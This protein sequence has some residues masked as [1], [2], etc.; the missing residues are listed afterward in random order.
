MESQ[1]QE[2]NL[3]ALLVVDIKVNQMI[4]S[5]MLR[6]FQVETTVVH[7]GKEAVQLFLEGETFDIVLSDNLMPMMTGPEAISKIRAMGT[8]DVTI[9]GVSVD[10]NSMEAFKAAGANVCVPKPM[11]LEI[12]EGILQE[13]MSKKNVAS[14]YS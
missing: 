5:A 10:T 11:T 4:L 3:R 1:A 13:V 14:A 2:Y 12:L 6:K 8:T 9:V 7:N